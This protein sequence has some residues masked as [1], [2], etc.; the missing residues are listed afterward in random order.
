MTEPITRSGHT[1]HIPVMGTGFSIDTAMRV[2]KYGVSTVISLVDDVLI[3]Q[4][5]KYHCENSGTPYEEIGRRDED[6]RAR[7]ITAYLDL[8][9]GLI[10]KQV[11]TLQASPFEEGSDISR[12]FEMLP[13]SPQ[14]SAYHQILAADDPT[15]KTRM[16]NDLRSL[17][18]PGTID[19]N[20]M[21]KIDRDIYV[22]G[23]KSAPEFADAMSGLRGYA[24]SKL[25]SA[26]IFSAGMN[27]RL[28]T[29]AS[30]FA[31]FSPDEN[32]VLKKK[33]ILKVSDLRSAMI[34][35]KFLAKRGLWVSEFRIESG[36][37]C[38]GHA[39]ATKGLLMGPIM[40]E[41]KQ[42]KDEL[43]QTLHTTYCKARKGAS[44]PAIDDAPLDMRITAQGGIGTALENDLLLQYYRLDGTGWAT[45]FLLV[46]EVANVDEN[47]LKMLQDAKEQDV[48][49]SA[50]SPL[51]TPFW[52]LNRSASEEVRRQRVQDGKPGSP[53]PKGYLVLNSEF[54]DIPICL[55]S[56]AYQ[57]RKIEHLP[58]EGYTPEQLE[59]V[60]E[61]IVAKACICNDLAGG[62]TVKFGID[63]KATT[64]V[65]CGPNITN[66]SKIATFQEMVSHI[67][68]RLSLL[69]NPERP[70]MFIRE[71]SLYMDD[72]R[73]EFMEFT[74]DV[75][76]RDPKFFQEF[77]ENML[78]GIEYYR[79]QVAEFIDEKRQHFLD[80]LDSIRS[81]LEQ[82]T[83]EKPQ[84]DV[85]QICQPIES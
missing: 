59:F 47:H 60:K 25:N 34:Q 29:Y 81:T 2:A 65:C 31:D 3:E 13:E 36:L 80:D 20:I 53:C 1:F 7:R 11:Q 75:S 42:R 55:A 8:L 10:R 4:M 14:K 44:G 24:N 27:Q 26:I 57:K 39:F 52:S 32:G 22:K 48:H 84:T 23:E 66:F 15:E 49:L 70:H 51:S 72:L 6:A 18:V 77:R 9:D 71:L 30:T 40:E 63:E 58:E 83:F 5:R 28:Y 56:R 62:A 73:K 19:V 79:T 12:Y 50:A 43:Q 78:S 54:T 64:S 85:A 82:M 69:T 41:F 21:T 33:I 17:A 38:G 68:G 76:T 45:P 46:P 74:L 67:Y 61:N 16:Q 37:N 35:G